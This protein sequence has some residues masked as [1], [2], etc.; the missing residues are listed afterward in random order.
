M[1]YL[2][3]T[4]ILNES[5]L[6]LYLHLTMLW[7]P[8]FFFLSKYTVFI[9]IIFSFLSYSLYFSYL[10]SFMK[11]RVVTA[12]NTQHLAQCLVRLNKNLFKN[13]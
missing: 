7:G 9:F 13:D 6:P 8:G 3:A 10:E 2:P 4:R 12:I 11:T 5:L 1:R